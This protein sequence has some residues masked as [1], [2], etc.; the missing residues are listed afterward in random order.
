MAQ[1]GNPFENTC[2]LTAVGVFAILICVVI[3]PR[4]G[5]R[6]I[7]LTTSLIVCGFCQLIVAAVWTTRDPTEVRK[8][9][10]IIVGMSVIY[11]VSYNGCMASFAWLVGGELPRQSLRS[12]T[13][14]LAAGVG[15]I[16]AWLAAFTAPYFIVCLCSDCR[17]SAY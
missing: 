5:R 6:R 7:F 14:G 17:V 2:I 1:V 9:G 15:F 12:Y 13:F 11:I 4:Y 8:T 3:M 10:R 16:G